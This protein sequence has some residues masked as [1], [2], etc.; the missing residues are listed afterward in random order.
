[1]VVLTYDSC[2]G[3]RWADRAL[4]RIREEAGAIDVAERGRRPGRCSSPPGNLLHVPGLHVSVATEPDG[5]D[6]IRTY[7]SEAEGGARSS[8]EGS[9]HATRQR[10]LSVQDAVKRVNPILRGWVNYFRIGN[11]SRE[12][13][14]V[15]EGVELKIRRF[16]VKKLKRR[17]L[18]WTRWSSKTVYG[19]WGLFDD[20]QVRYRR[21]AKAAPTAKDP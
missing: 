11:S 5:P 1:M 13:D 16:A 21:R 15:R 19:T 10:H 3:R 12:F 20:Y 14:V 6:G 17:G 9:K 7:E 2:K 8:A 4:E 18:G